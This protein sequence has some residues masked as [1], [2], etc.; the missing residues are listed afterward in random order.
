MKKSYRGTFLIITLIIL[1]V[2]FI[3]LLSTGNYEFKKTYEP[4]TALSEILPRFRLID[5]D[6]LPVKTDKNRNSSNDSKDIV[7]GAKKQLEIGSKN[8]FIEGSG[9]SNYYKGGD[10]PQDWAICTDIVARSF[11]EAGYDLREI[12]NEDISENFDE[13]PLRKLWGQTRPDI[14]IDYR[15]IQNMEVFF[16]RKAQNL[17]RVF[18]P[19]SS[20]NLD[21]WLPGD[22][23]FFDMD[24]NGFS[25]NAGIISDTTARN[26]SPKVIF[27]YIEPGYT[28]QD[29]I[30]SKEAITGHYRY[31]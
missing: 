15:R 18:D 26:G 12:I 30:L 5:L 13:Y 20:E 27:N 31:P 4:P 10:P 22:V 9:E 11:K 25:D 8:I 29:N 14:D 3:V 6:N 17:T 21:S 28:V 2:V 7:I 23:V 1:L 19:A 24:K 16:K